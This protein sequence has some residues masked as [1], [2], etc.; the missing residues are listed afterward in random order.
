MIFYNMNIILYTDSYKK[1][2][3]NLRSVIFPYYKMALE[4]SRNKSTE[5]VEQGVFTQ[6]KSKAGA[7]KFVVLFYS[8]FMYEI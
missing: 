3:Y 6:S 7:Q 4:Q 8:D 2:F 5:Q 1:I